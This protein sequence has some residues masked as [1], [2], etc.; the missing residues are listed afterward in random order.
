MVSCVC[1]NRYTP[2]SDRPE[3]SDDKPGYGIGLEN[4]RRRLQL[5]Y[6]SAH[7][8]EI[9]ADGSLFTVALSF[10]ASKTV[11]PQSST[12]SSPQS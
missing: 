9:T 1:S 6:P 12:I 11:I 4:L 8:L 2:Q 3:S 5:R 7:S 10:D